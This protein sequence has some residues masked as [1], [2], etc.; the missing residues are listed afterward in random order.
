MTDKRLKI[1]IVGAGNI[2]QLLAF[3]LSNDCD[4]QLLSHRVTRLSSIDASLTELDGIIS[5]RHFPVIPSCHTSIADLDVI[6]VCVKAYQVIEALEPLLPNLNPHAHLIL[7][8]NGMGPYLSIVPRL[9]VTQGLSLATTSQGAFRKSQWHVTHSGNGLTQIGHIDGTPLTIS[10]QKHI[11]KNI[12]NCEWKEDI[13]TA[14]WHKLAVNAVINPLTSLH[15]CRNGDIGLP[16]FDL[17]VKEVIVELIQVAKA[18]G[19]LLDL[20]E[21]TQRVYDVIKLTANNRSSM[22]QDVEAGRQTE[23]EF[24]NGF[25]EKQAKKHEIACP[26]NQELR[27]AILEL[28]Q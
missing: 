23:I 2:G 14:L 15:Q 4:V 1:G 5:Q 12:P 28:N 10:A 6:L 9:K 20:T 24:I 18:E 8:H 13:L 27:Q 22:L 7:M 25:I 17:V 3:Q 19:V 26:K 16:K 11:L 21:V